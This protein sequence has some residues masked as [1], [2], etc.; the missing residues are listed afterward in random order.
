[1][2]RRARVVPFV[3]ALLAALPLTA[4][5]QAAEP[6]T[7]LSYFT[8]D[9]LHAEAFVEGAA[10]FYTT[11]LTP[12]LEE[13]TVLSWGITEPLIRHGDEYTHVAYF[14]AVDW[15]TIGRVV[16]AETAMFDGLD[17]EQRRQMLE[18]FLAGMDVSARRDRVVRHLVLAGGP[19]ADAPPGFIIVGYHQVRPGKGEAA[20]GIYTR[21]L[22]PVY[23]RL[24]EEKVINAYGVYVAEIHGKYDWTH[25]GWAILPDLAAVDTLGRALAE[26]DASLPAD[27]KARRAAE[28]GE[29]FVLEAHYDDLLRILRRSE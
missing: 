22:E 15:A 24:L 6:L 23:R 21:S 18:S 14:T 28:L 5:E 16:A 8:V 7:V 12:L 17:A 26:I 9:P 13:G 20:M 29:T 10:G 25:V 3:V 19:G 11:V 2:A 1:M 27:E 4:Q